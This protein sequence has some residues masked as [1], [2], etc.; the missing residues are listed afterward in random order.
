MTRRGDITGEVAMAALNRLMSALESYRGR[1]RLVRL[2]LSVARGPG[3]GPNLRDGETEAGEGAG[4]LSIPRRRGPCPSW[5]PTGLLA[6]DVWLVAAYA[7]RLDIYSGTNQILFGH[8]G[9]DLT[10]GV[11]H[12]VVPNNLT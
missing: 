2:G 10:A 1:D 3:I 11:V 8:L 12:Y 5:A 7:S 9:S 6:A 4:S